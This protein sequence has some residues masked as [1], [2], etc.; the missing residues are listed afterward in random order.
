MLETHREAL[1][2]VADAL[3]V[4]E[5]LK[6]DRLLEIMAQYAPSEPV[7]ISLTG[8]ADPAATGTAGGAESPESRE[9]SLAGGPRS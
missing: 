4:E 3:W 6:G 7:D 1:N 9:L 8:V 5:E 2:A